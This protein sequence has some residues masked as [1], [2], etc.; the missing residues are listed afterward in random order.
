M[1]YRPGSYSFPLF[2]FGAYLIS[3]SIWICAR[4]F[5]TVFHIS[6]GGWTIDIPQR[7]LVVLL[8]NIGP[9]VSAS[10]VVGLAEG[11]A[12]VRH[13]WS[14]LANWRLH[15]AWI[16]FACLL[17]PLLQSIA[18]LGYWLL[19]GRIGDTG[20]PIRLFLL[21][22]LNLPFGPLWEEIGWRGFLLP[23]L[24]TKYNGLLASMILACVWGPW[25]LPIYWGSPF[26]WWFWFLAMV[27]G[28]AILLTWVYNR[29]R[30]SLIPV[31][32]LH[33]TANTTSLYLL[34][35]TMRRGGMQ[36]FRFIVVSICC[37]A[38]VVA[39]SVGPSLSK[40][41]CGTVQPDDQLPPDS[42]R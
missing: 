23:R 29:S 13:L 24:Q 36:G 16:L 41:P 3:W 21:I 10:A 20:G 17:I 40:D 39:V 42:S 7:S 37:A 15:P 34:G 35:P 26:E 22:L 27:F 5:H 28:L 32:L 18:L 8:G 4:H 6:I 11:W 12:G 9:G 25:H 38:L 33:V 30:G 1:R 2:V 19:G 31:V 14:G